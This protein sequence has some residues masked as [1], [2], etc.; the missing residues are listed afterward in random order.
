MQGGGTQ[1]SSRVVKHNLRTQLGGFIEGRRLGHYLDF[2]VVVI[3][4]GKHVTEFPTADAA[5]HPYNVSENVA[6]NAQLEIRIVPWL[7]AKTSATEKLS[8]KLDQE[9]HNFWKAGVEQM[10]VEPDTSGARAKRDPKT[11]YGR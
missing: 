4:P 2:N 6:E 5:F 3:P 7:I 11:P 8:R 1:V 9:I 10:F